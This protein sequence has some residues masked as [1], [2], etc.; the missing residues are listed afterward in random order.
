MEYIHYLIVIPIILVIIILQTRVF[1]NALSKIDAFRGI[2]PSNKLSY[3]VKQITINESKESNDDLPED[4]NE[5]IW[6][7]NDSWVEG[8]EREIDVSQIEIDSS[9]STLG[10]IKD[11]LNMYL[12]KNKGAV[13]DFSLM[14]DVVE[15]YCGAEEEEISVMQPIPLYMGLMGTMIGIIVGISL[16]AVQ[17]GVSGVNLDNVSSM[18]TCVAIAMV[19]SFFGILFTTIISWKSKSAKT[20]IESNKN[21]FYSWLQTELLPVLSGN[22]VTALSLLQ[23]NLMTFNRTFQGNIQEFDT[24]LSNVRQVSRDQAEAL[25]AISRI[26][27]NRVAQA[28]ISVLQA[29]QNSVGQIDR[30]SQYLRQVNDYVLAV[31]ALNDNL[32]NYLDRTQAI[33]R[34]GAFFERELTQVQ[35]R[36]DYIKQVVGSVDTTLEGSFNQLIASM[37]SYIEQLKTQTQSEIEATKSAYEAQ[38]TAFVEQLKKQQGDVATKTE[39]LNKVIQGIQSFADTKAAINNLATVSK[40]NYSKLDQILGAIESLPAEGGGNG[41]SRTCHKR[42]FFNRITDTILPITAVLAFILFLIDFIAK[43]F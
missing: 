9:N 39:D 22:T 11:A 37:N 14:K 7:N 27:I 35:K 41:Q 26:D 1:R 40:N 20:E 19:A 12:Q 21:Q 17:G 34:M 24:V 4:D 23:S 6:E 33:E 38:L 5:E 28:N 36:E 2:F 31:N 18:M 30:F 43:H 16:I 3:A 15:R 25:T 29:L 32:S 13:S 10:N 42:S 8:Y